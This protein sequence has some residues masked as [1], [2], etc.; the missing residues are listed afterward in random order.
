MNRVLR[1]IV[2]LSGALF[3]VIGLRWVTD[4]AAAAEAL[5]MPLLSGVGRSTQIGDMAA[6]F[7]TLGI[8]ILMGAITGQRAWF[9][10]PILLLG[11]AAGFRIVAWLVH[12]AA[13]AM[14]LI[15]PEVIVAAVLALAAIRLGE[16]R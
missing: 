10:A 2:A 1:A 14:H 11:L 5:G 15:A 16:G 7:L 4:P 9:H 3:V 6:F 13:L 12:D 8:T